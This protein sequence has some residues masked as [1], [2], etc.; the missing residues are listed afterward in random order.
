VHLA[1]DAAGLVSSLT[2]EGIYAA[3]V[4]GEEVARRVLDPKAPEPKTRR[5]LRTKRAHDGLARWLARPR[6]RAWTLG[7]LARLAA[8]PAL[9]R[10]LAGWFLRP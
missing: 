2:A 5:W 1:G 8:R 9:R 10:P 4:T 7:T 3:I 6:P